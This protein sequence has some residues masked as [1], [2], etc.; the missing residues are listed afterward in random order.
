MLVSGT[1]SRWSGLMRIPIAVSLAVLL[2]S[3]A[4]ADLD[5]HLLHSMCKKKNL[6][7]VAGYVA[8]VTDK[9]NNDAEFVADPDGGQAG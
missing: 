8:G 9:A 1:D 4:A 2:V 5:G 7:F 6:E 3:P